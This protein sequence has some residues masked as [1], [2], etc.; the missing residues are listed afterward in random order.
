MPFPLGVADGTGK[1][2]EFGTGE[3]VAFLQAFSPL[4]F[5]L[6]AGGIVYPSCGIQQAMVP[7]RAEGI[8][9][10]EICLPLAS[11]HSRVGVEEPIGDGFA[12]GTVVMVQLGDGIAAMVGFGIEKEAI[13]PLGIAKSIA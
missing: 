11:S 8:V 3:F 5:G 10:I 6:A 2:I 9:T 12:A 4:G 7:C 13:A 1:F